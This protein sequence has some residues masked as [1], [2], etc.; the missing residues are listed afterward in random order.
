MP[1][2]QL[3]PTETT[4]SVLGSTIYIKTEYV[5]DELPDTI[6]AFISDVVGNKNGVNYIEGELII[7]MKNYPNINFILDPFGDLIVISLEEDVAN[8]SINSNGDLIYIV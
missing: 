2:S 1:S 7:T 5:K 3:I 8:Y 4:I 6:E